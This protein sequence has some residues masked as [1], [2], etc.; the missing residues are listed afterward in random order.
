[1]NTA[2][3][4]NGYTGSPF[5]QGGD[6]YQNY[7]TYNCLNPGTANSV[8]SS[9][10]SAQL[11]DNCSS[12]QT[13]NNGSCEN[14]V[15]ACSANSQCGT[16][17]YV[18][19][20]FCK[21]G[22]VYQNYKTY[23]CNNGG[24]SSSYCSNT[25]ASQLKTNC[26]ANQTC[27]DGTC[28]DQNSLI[29][30]CYA[31]PNPSK[32][33]Q[34][35]SFIASAIGG[36]GI[37][38]Y[39]WSGACTGSS[40]ICSQLF[41]QTGTYNA[42]LNVVSGGQSI[43][44]ICSAV[45]NQNCS[46]HYSKRCLG[47]D[48][49]WYDSCG[50]QEGVFQDCTTTNK[51]CNNGVCENVNIA[52]SSASQCGTTGYIGSPFC[53]GNS[54]YQNYKTYTCLNP[55]TA[56]SVC[57]DS[58][59]AKLKT[60]CA[61]NQT[62]SLGVCENVNI[63]CSNN[64][65][66]GTNGYTGS[67]FCQ[68]GDVYQNYRTYT[69]NNPGTA[70]S[71][72][73]DS[74]APQLKTN[75][76]LGQTCANGSCTNVTIACSNNTACGTNGYIGSPFCQSGNVY[77]NYKTYTCNNP[78]TANSSCSESTSAQLKNTCTSDETCSNGFCVNNVIA[79]VTNS[80]CGTNAYTGDSY[81]QGG[82]VYQNYKTY[83]CNN[84][85]T[86]NSV[87][88][89]STAP[90]LKTNCASGQTCSN[91]SCE[92]INIACS[93]NTACGSNGYTGSPFCQGN[94]I[95]QNYRTYTCN[96]PGTANSYCSESTSAQQK[97]NCYG[98]QTC[99]NGSCSNVNIA[100]SN[101]NACG[102]NGYTGSPFCQGNNV[103]QNYRT[104]TCN[105][106]GTSN[107][108]CSESTSAQL[109]ETCSTNQGCSN[110]YCSTQQSYL[111]VQT[112]SATNTYNNQATLNGYISGVNTNNMNYVWFQWGTT[113]SY[114]YNGYETNHQT[115]NYTGSFSQNISGL[116]PGVVYYFR[117]VGQNSN[118]QIVYGQDLTFQSGQVLGITD[119]STGL[120]NNFLVDSFFLPLMIALAGIWL[121]KS[122][123]F[124]FNSWIDSR[125]IKHTDYLANKKLKTRIA[126]IQARENFN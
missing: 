94:N 53:M 44:A 12:N 97:E 30:S 101:N 112:N 85:G 84:P 60:N 105:N 111:T 92:N 43:G 5:C 10:T 122:R 99:S 62:C 70:N 32:T 50:N 65:A 31:T 18:D 83:T 77:Q 46:S 19:S 100:C 76:A 58:T 102:A 117:A 42:V 45:V 110:G 73:S 25:V 113:T 34:S 86:A 123:V 80:Q 7:K 116:T 81:C 107:S 75:C 66:C 36:T 63:A 57:S 13:C 71:V 8:C 106:S 93:N 88:S 35:V 68:N 79:C 17:G 22:D 28:V 14:L 103:Y 120:T 78:G 121:F 96:N 49:Y 29:V 3:G 61:A 1:N 91:G 20:P 89:D 124:G 40:Q 6:V 59:T 104:Y 74:T 38:T 33:D 41:S 56:N 26:T 39:T 90:Q 4:T 108:Y 2:C 24:T 114:A 64:T 109:K 48:V 126:E 21:S 55:G 82:D 67:P 16:N 87:C 95:Y 11:K 9:S 119:V 54:T 69:C 72:C 27:G 47:N 23:V 125:R 37:Y 52:C 15:I 98:N 51:V 118:G 115:A